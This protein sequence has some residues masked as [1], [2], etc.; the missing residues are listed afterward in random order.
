MNFKYLYILF[1]TLTFSYSNCFIIGPPGA[2][3][4]TVAT[5]LISDNN[6]YVHISTGELLRREKERNTE[7]GK[8]I[9]NNWNYT[10]LEEIAFEL[11]EQEISNTKGDII[12]D[13]CPKTVSDAKKV[14]FIVNN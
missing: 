10:L 2:G 7:K 5:Q 8:F 4:G 6:N 1:T 14:Y 3:K 11:L 12:L 9:Q 13:G